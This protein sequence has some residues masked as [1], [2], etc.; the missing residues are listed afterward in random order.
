MVTLELLGELEGF[1]AVFDLDLYR[2]SR[3][4]LEYLLLLP[5]RTDDPFIREILEFTRTPEARLP[6]FAARFHTLWPALGFPH[7]VARQ[8][9]AAT[10]RS[11]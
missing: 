10:H 1:D 11:R 7:R 6:R 5:G 3:E 2:R 4:R 9:K 8:V